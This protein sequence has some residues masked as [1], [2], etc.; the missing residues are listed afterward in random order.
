MERLPAARCREEVQDDRRDLLGEPR[1]NCVADLCVLFRAIALEKVVIRKR[2]K[3]G[4][5]SHRQA[6]TLGRIG[7]DEVMPV[8]G[9][10]G[11]NR[12]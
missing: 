6:A 9:D 10:M 3:T 5:L 7:M 8:L 1:R 2:L 4:G 12:G 11:D